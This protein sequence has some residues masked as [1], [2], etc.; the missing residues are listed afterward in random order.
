M[1]ANG[2]ALTALLF[3]PKIFLRAPFFDELPAIARV[4][5][6]KELD[7]NDAIGAKEAE[8]LAKLTPSRQEPPRLE[9]ELSPGQMCSPAAVRCT[10]H[11]RPGSVSCLEWRCHGEWCARTH[12]TPAQGFRQTPFRG[13]GEHILAQGRPHESM[14]TIA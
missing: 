5:L 1:E 12:Q 8:V 7:L 14:A 6:F 10:G 4:A 13:A 2:R 3:S 11:R 9:S